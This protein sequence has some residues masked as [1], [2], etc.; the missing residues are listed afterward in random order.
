MGSDRLAVLADGRLRIGLLVVS[1]ALGALAFPVLDWWLFGWVWLAPTLCC[2]LARSPRRALADGWLAGTVFFVVLLRWLEYTFAHYS[3]IPWPLGVLPLLALAAYCGLYAGA[4]A[5]GIA[6]LRPRIGAGWSLALTPAL[7]VAGEWIRGHL[8]D[9]FAWGLLGYSQHAVLAVIQIAELGGVY[10]VSLLLVAVNVAITAMV[11]LGW[12]RAWPGALAAAAL[13]LLSLGFG[14]RALRDEGRARGETV[15][16][17]EVAVIQPVI[18]QSIKWDPV[19]NAEIIDVHE[20]LTR[21]AARSHPALIAWPETAAAI[22]LRGDPP[23]L[24][25]L[26]ALSSELRIPLL[27]GSVDRQDAPSAKFLNSAFLLTGQGITAKYDKIHLVPFGEY[28]PLGWL[29]GFVRSWA[30]FISDFAAG[31]RQTIFPLAGAPFG[32]VICYEVVFPEL[33]RGFVADGATFMV[34]ITNDAWFGGTSGPWQHLGMLPLRAVEHRIAIARAANTGVSAFIEPS[35]R[36]RPMLPLFE[37]GIL[38]HRLALRT[39]TTLYTRLGDWVAYGCLALGAAG[40]GLAL[41]RRS[42]ETCSGN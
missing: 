2:A 32:T 20:R 16:G 6:W 17:V 4:V 5:A 27:I 40:C 19:R 8:M 30:E 25:R 39:R 23:L 42:R 38:R 14:A 34:N 10:A 31:E 1:G 7:W 15:P 21:E 12:R 37:R 18:E 13:L 36:V 41:L 33:F 29:I 24:A 3:A 28:V 22:F 35:G 26:S 11:A 9:G